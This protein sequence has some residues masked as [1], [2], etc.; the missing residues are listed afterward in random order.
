MVVQDA[1]YLF[2]I[3]ITNVISCESRFL[4]QSY[5]QGH[6]GK[7]HSNNVKKNLKQISERFQELKTRYCHKK[8]MKTGKLTG[9]LKNVAL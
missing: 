4:S 2:W 3:L 9:F 8:W 1:C 5:T 6:I 7:R